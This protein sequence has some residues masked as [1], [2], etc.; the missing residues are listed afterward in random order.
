M[1]LRSVGSRTTY[2]TDYRCENLKSFPYVAEWSDEI[3]A[4]YAVASSCCCSRFIRS[5]ELLQ[6]SE[7][8][9]EDNIKTYSVNEVCHCVDLW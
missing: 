7:S 6:K 2:Y 8:Q 3:A 5:S 1:F 9:W 4:V